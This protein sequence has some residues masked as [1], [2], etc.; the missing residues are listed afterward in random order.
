MGK[1]RC[2]VYARVST[3]KERGLQDPET[4]LRPLRDFAT[5]QGWEAAA[6]YIDREGGAKADRKQFAAMMEA[7][8]RRQFD[9]LLFWSLDRFGRGGIVPTLTDLKRL[10]G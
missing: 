1:Q 5:T 6:E 10:D 9:V 4:Q 8:S 3:K 2:A 7:A